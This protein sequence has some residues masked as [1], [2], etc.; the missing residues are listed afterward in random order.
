MNNHSDALV[1]ILTQEQTRTR[2]I[3]E[4]LFPNAAIN[5]SAQ[6][7]NVD[8]YSE[9]LN[10]FTSNIESTLQLE[11]SSVHSSNNKTVVKNHRDNGTTD[12]AVDDSVRQTTEELIL[13]NAKLKT[14]VDEYKTIVA[15][16]VSQG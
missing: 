12:G 16:T 1:A 13:Q 3:L 6:N 10:Q 7:R 4:R 5:T 9:W 8:D 2:E 14:T 11:N 15:E